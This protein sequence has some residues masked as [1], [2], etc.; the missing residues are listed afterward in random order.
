MG[1]RLRVLLTSD[2]ELTLFELRTA[3]TVPQRVKDRAQMVRLNAQGWY[4]EKIAQHFHCHAQTV[5]KT[6]YRW[7]DNGL[8]GLWDAPHPG[9]QRRWSEADMEY[10]ESCL[11]EE[12][13]TYN[14][15][16]LAQKLAVERQVTLSAGYLREVLEKRGS[17]GSEPDTLTM[18]SKIQWNEPLSKQT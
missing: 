10:L 4:V 7:R 13:R 17:F 8:A 18:E 2:E 15:Q 12:Q 11:R 14:S 16:Q 9:A 1:A 3:S 6:L 5:R